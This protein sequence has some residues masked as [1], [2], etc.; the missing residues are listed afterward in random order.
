MREIYLK[1][2]KPY[3]SFLLITNQNH[4]AIPDM[5]R[6]LVLYRGLREKQV[7]IVSKCIDESFYEESVYKSIF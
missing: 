3:Y 4:L 6:K 5:N 1:T 2:S 7:Q